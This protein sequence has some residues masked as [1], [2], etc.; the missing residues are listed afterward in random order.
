M[1]K[2][3]LDHT[4][5]FARRIVAGFGL[6]DR[7]GHGLFTKQVFAGGDRIQKVSSVNMK[8]RSHNYSVDVLQVQQPSMG[9]EG[10]H[11][12]SESLCRFLTAGVKIGSRRKPTQRK[13]NPLLQ[14]FLSTP[15]HTTF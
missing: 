9:G 4:F 6:L 2:S 7:P 5:R 10:P 12:G 11:A 1:L 13:L 14:P 15:P 3:N 8:G